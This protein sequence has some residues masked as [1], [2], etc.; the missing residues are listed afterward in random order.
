MHVVRIT[1]Y[2]ERFFCRK[3]ILLYHMLWYI[4]FKF[5]KLYRDM[6]TKI[7]IG[8]SCKNVYNALHY[9]Y[10]SYFNKM[11]LLEFLSYVVLRYRGSRSTAQP[12]LVLVVLNNVAT[13]LVLGSESNFQ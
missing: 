2:Q 9:K 4:I 10:R 12:T 13:L 8:P 6:E 5:G 7:V 11:V 3:V 1:M